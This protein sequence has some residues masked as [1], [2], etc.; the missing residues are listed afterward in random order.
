[1]FFISETCM[2][3]IVRNVTNNINLFDASWKIKFLE[4]LY[5]LRIGMTNILYCLGRSVSFSK[6]EN[7]NDFILIFQKYFNCRSLPLGPRKPI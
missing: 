6:N 7:E 1:M 3:Q 5:K 4:R 2:F